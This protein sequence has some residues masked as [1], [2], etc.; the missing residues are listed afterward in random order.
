MKAATVGI[1][2]EAW[3]ALGGGVSSTTYASFAS[4][5]L[6]DDTPLRSTVDA[7]TRQCDHQAKLIAELEREVALRVTGEDAARARADA[8]EAAREYALETTKVALHRERDARERERESM[9]ERL[10]ALERAKARE[11]DERAAAEDKVD[12]A[13]NKLLLRMAEN[14]RSAKAAAEASCADVDAVRAEA[15]ERVD[16]L[17]TALQRAV[18][19]IKSGEQERNTMRAA[20][21]A[22]DTK[23]QMVKAQSKKEFAR[24]IT[25]KQYEEDLEAAALEKRNLGVALGVSEEARGH[26]GNRLTALELAGEAELAAAAATNARIDATEAKLGELPTAAELSSRLSNIERA[27]KKLAKR[28]EDDAQALAARLNHMTAD[29]A[30]SRKRTASQK[31]L[32][33]LREYLTEQTAGQLRKLQATLQKRV[34]S[35]GVEIGNLKM[36]A[37]GAPTAEDILRVK[38]RLSQLGRQLKELHAH[39][40]GLGDGSGTPDSLIF[41]P[42]PGTSALKRRAEH[43]GI[44]GD[45]SSVGTEAGSE[46][47]FLLGDDGDA[48]DNELGM[49]EEIDEALLLAQ[50]HE[51]EED[52]DDDG[53]LGMI[54]EEGLE[55]VEVDEI[56]VDDLYAKV[57]EHALIAAGRELAASPR[58]GDGAESPLP[59]QP[60]SPF[61]GKVVENDGDMASVDMLLDAGILH[62]LIPTMKAK[63]K[64]SAMRLRHR[65]GKEAALEKHDA[66]TIGAAEIALEVQ[67]RRRRLSVIAEKANALDG[68]SGEINTKVLFEWVK[69]QKQLR[70]EARAARA[71]RAAKALKAS[72]LLAKQKRAAAKRAAAKR[73]AAMAMAR[74][75]GSGTG[76]TRS[77]P[78]AAGPGHVHARAERK[79]RETLRRKLNHQSE[80][81]K[82]Y[83]KVAEEVQRTFAHS[84]L[85]SS[86][87]SCGSVVA[88]EGN[89][90]LGMRKT[91]QEKLDAE[92]ALASTA[93]STPTAAPRARRPSTAPTKPKVA[94]GVEVPK[95]I[96]LHSRRGAFGLDV[97]QQL[98]KI[99]RVTAEDV[100]ASPW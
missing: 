32:S 4:G 21:R 9:R 16:E 3:A 69:E 81:L 25:L 30:A 27:A 35:N 90:P 20:T 31:E 76:S 80:L 52:A 57:K 91:L 18:A 83:G 45:G 42:H 98:P 88:A 46:D 8:A 12:A 71:L 44:G 100:K 65:Q 2:P 7:L 38:E 97:K 51:A 15:Q 60:L 1:I 22:M 84:S 67:C 58:V 79:Q 34:K 63:S 5:A 11:H 17:S 61:D 66:G 95:L 59:A 64:L 29:A 77:S 53:S 74:S 24:C 19:S 94:A 96:S 41:S 23:L 68:A 49:G 75:G 99:K 70:E 87:L 82:L 10:G 86:C 92:L 6:V 78:R 48:L 73:A 13:V 39:G 93:R 89:V 37:D 28:L 85:T 14:A 47:G 36:R 62:A 26:L 43:L 55:D 54:V 40:G 33:A 56:E 50:V 72:G